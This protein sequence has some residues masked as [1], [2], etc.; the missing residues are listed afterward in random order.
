MN[1]RDTSA[2]RE[3]ELK[4][5]DEACKV[6]TAQSSKSV[7]RAWGTF[8]KE[9]ISTTA[10]SESAAIKRWIDRANYSANE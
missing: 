3:H 7:W 1:Q 10:P 5:D 8:R 6:W 2:S 9:V 4:I